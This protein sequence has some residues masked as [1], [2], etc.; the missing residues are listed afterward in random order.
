MTGCIREELVQNCDIENQYRACDGCHTAGHGGKKFAP[1]HSGKVG[2]NQEGRLNHAKKDIGSSS[3]SKGS[4]DTHSFLKK[5][6]K[7][8][9]KSRKDSPI[10]EQG[11]QSAHHQ[12]NRQGLESENETRTGK[13]FC[14]R[15]ISAA[16]VSEGKGCASLCGLLQK[17]HPFIQKQEEVLA[18]RKFEQKSCKE[19]LD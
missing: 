11:G 3:Y 15:Q 1:G 17:K 14:K 12:D 10:G 7:K 8:A 18:Q 4:A 13:C 2:L 9:N 5:A 6:G 19:K 16:Y